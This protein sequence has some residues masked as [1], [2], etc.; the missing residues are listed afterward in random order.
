MP[1]NLDNKKEDNLKKNKSFQDLKNEVYN[2][3]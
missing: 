2:K 1:K 3:E